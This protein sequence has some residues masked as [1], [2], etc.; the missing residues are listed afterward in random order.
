[1]WGKQFNTVDVNKM[2]VV[3]GFG[4]VGRKGNVFDEDSTE[5]LAALFDYVNFSRSFS[6]REK[7]YD[8]AATLSHLTNR[9]E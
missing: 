6:G 4:V 3:L 9:C 5:P 8:V 7:Q 1:M 2:A